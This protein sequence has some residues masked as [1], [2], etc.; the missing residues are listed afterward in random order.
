VLAERPVPTTA[1]VRIHNPGREDIPAD[2]WGGVLE[3]RFW[4]VDDDSLSLAERAVAALLG[5]WPDL[6]TDLGNGLF[7][8]G[9]WPWRPFLAADAMA[10]TRFVAG[11]PDG[12][13][14]LVVSCEFGRSRSRGVAEALAV[15]LGVPADGMSRG[16]AN[17]RVARLMA[18]APAA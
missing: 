10:I 2:G 6:C 13:T 5:R 16:Y 9:G 15:R 14:D 3:L 17:R 4:D 12:V 1:V 7:A 11:L 18:A 8:K